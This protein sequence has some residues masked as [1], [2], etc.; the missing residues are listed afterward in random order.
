MQYRRGSVEI[1]PVGLLGQNSF[2][3][4]TENDIKLN[5]LTT[6]TYS[7]RIYRFCGFDLHMLCENKCSF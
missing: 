6:T 1:L 4:S 7:D 5:T 3:P 2:N